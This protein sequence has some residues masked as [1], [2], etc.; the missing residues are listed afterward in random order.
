M[1]VPSAAPLPPL[2]RP[3][4]FTLVEIMI[5]VVIIGILAAIGIPAIFSNKRNTQNARFVSDLRTFAQ[6]FE[7]LA[8]K[9][10]AWPPDGTPGVVPA[11]ASGEISDKAW[12]ATTSV[13]GNWDWDYQQFGFTAG[14]SVYEPTVSVE[15]MREI[16]RKIDDGDLNTGN[17]RAR[18]QGYIFIL[19]P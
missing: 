1:N 9:N 3:R 15:Q 6:G 8:L 19:Q 5:V 11:G 12:A 13:G 2:T 4:G 7:T 10:G 18:S 16:D 17:F 14:I